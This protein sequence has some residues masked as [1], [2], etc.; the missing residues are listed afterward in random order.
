[1]ATRTRIVV[2]GAGYSGWIAARSLA[3][4][5]DLAV[6]VVNPSDRFTERVRLH[7]L[8][9]GQ[10]TRDLPLRELARGAKVRLVV[11]TATALDPERRGVRTAGGADL[12][13]DQLVYAAGSVGDR[14]AVP[15]AAEHA[16]SVDDTASARR[17]AR[18]LRSGSGDVTVVG[19][20]LTGVETATEIAESF[21]GHTVRL[22][23]DGTFGAALSDR[24][25]RH[26][27]TAFTRLGIDVLDE[28]RV[29]EVHTDGLTLTDGTVLP[30]GTVVWTTGFR[31]P[32]LAARSGL[33]VDDAGRLIV[34]STVRSV[35]HPEVHG[36]G[37]A[38]VLRA[39]DGRPLRMAC[40]TGLPSGAYVAN[41]ITA[42]LRGESPR[43]WR[44]R[45]VT[46][47][48]SLGRRDALVQ[49][50]RA[51]DTPIEAVLTGRTGAV[52]K[53][54]IVRGTVLVQRHPRWASAL[55]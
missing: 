51:D 13:Y 22:V 37:D 35:S 11:D 1:M 46:R 42:R 6:T 49:A 14:S 12:P 45:Y 43:P 2:I 50:V 40:A 24:G 29:T 25:R 18:R 8:A 30:T 32:D 31:V 17:L 10:P 36:V 53:E 33:A 28:V 39:G 41:A 48:I 38:A 26:L 15:G 21:P 23:T 27:R 3:R 55:A 44:F 16:F 5:R 9:T 7:Q 47:C 52:V 4:H 34:D 20:G 54:A 19:G